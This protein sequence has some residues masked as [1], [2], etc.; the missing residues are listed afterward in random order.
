MAVIKA[1]Y[2]KKGR[3]KN[4]TPKAVK[5]VSVIRPGTPSKLHAALIFS[6]FSKA[7]ILAT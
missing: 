6:P 3:I 2:T 7:F 4:E 1:G 5:A